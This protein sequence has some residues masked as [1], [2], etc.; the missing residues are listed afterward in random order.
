M[1]TKSKSEL[2]KAITEAEYLIANPPSE[3]VKKIAE[4]SLEKAKKELADLGSASQ[5][6]KPSQQVV[7]GGGDTVTAI[8]AALKTY[9]ESNMGGGLDSESIR[10]M[11]SEYLTKN[12]IR[13]VSAFP[14][15]PGVYKKKF[16]P[17]DLQNL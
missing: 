2:E 17:S 15:R 11:I 3:A 13:Y 4:K 5:I 6:S 8:L 12:N 7:Q 14:L 1:A 16:V 9:M 10:S